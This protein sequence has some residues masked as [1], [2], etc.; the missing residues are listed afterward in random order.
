MTT[1]DIP[2]VRTRQASTTSESRQDLLS[3]AP[4]GEV[5]TAVSPPAA[6]VVRRSRFAR[7]GAMFTGQRYHHPQRERFVEEAAMSREMFRL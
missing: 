4:V 7:L 2:N 3:L 6:M 5:G 1:I